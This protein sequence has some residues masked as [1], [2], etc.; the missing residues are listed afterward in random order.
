MRSCRLTVFLALFPIGVLLSEGTT[1]SVESWPGFRGMGDSHLRS[2]RLP[3]SWSESSNLAWRTT[4]GGYGQSSPVLWGDTLFVTSSRGDQKDEMLIQALSISDGSERWT[5]ILKATQKVE[6]V[7]DMV[8]RAAPTPV[9]DENQVFVF[10]ESGELASFRHDGSPV[11]ERRLTAEFG[12]FKGGHGVG[13]SLVQAPDY[14]ILLVDH[15]GPSYLLCLDKKNGETVWKTEREERVSW[16]TPL[17][18]VVEG[19]ERLFISSNGVVEGYRLADGKRL[20]HISGLKKN[21]VASPTLAGE[22]LIIGSSDPGQSM[23]VRLGGEGDVSETHVA[24]KAQSA[25]SSFGSPLV[26]GDRA[27]FV[28]RAGV[29]Q[30]NSLKDGSSLWKYRLPSSTWASPLATPKF[31]YFF[32]KDGQAVVMKPGEAEPE[33]VERSALPLKEKDRHYGYAVSSN[34]IFIRSGEEVICLREEGR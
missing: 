8:S 11:W 3:R 34:A 19:E 26:H 20:W 25:S 28:N 22:R 7:S 2:D 12:E 27:Y 24:W 5:K 13:S 10:F 17:Y 14:L 6:K 30:V 21:T 4:L 29:L 9:V 16:T 18:A 1:K 31:L 33:I 23:A 15:S 32:C